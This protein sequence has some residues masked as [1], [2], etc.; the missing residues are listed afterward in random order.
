[1]CELLVAGFFFRN[2][3]VNGALFDKLKQ[4]KTCKFLRKSSFSSYIQQKNKQLIQLILCWLDVGGWWKEKGT[5]LGFFTCL[6]L[7]HV[8]YTIIRSKENL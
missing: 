4:D 7:S 6:F 5:R 8:Y 1:M 2:T 3:E